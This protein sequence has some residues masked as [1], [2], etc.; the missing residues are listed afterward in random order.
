MTRI[1]TRATIATAIFFGLITTVFAA[2][3]EFGGMCTQ[4]L[5][6][7]QK[8]QT[9]CSINATFNGKTYCFGNQDAEVKFFKDPTDNLA[10]AQ[11]YYNEIH[12]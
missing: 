11:A 8:V 5:A 1:T 3:G 12:K 9:D 4:G 7:H 10:R 6:E 2:T